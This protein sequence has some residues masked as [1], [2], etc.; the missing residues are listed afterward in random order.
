MQTTINIFA[1]IFIILPTVFEVVQD[2]V[3]IEHGKGDEK[4]RFG[5]DYDWLVRAG[6]FGVSCAIGALAWEWWKSGL[7]TGVCFFACFNYGLNIAR[8]KNIYHL[9]QNYLD[10]LEAMTMP[11]WRGL[12]IRVVVLIAALAVCFS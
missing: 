4:D 5:F 7:L 9:G 11:G 8:G 6:L 1:A 12:V 10:R 2:Y 3:Q